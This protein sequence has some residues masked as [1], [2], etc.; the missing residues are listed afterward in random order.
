[1]TTILNRILWIATNEYPELTDRLTQIA[2][3]HTKL[4]LELL[5]HRIKMD[6]VSKRLLEQ[7]IEN[8]IYERESILSYL[9]YLYDDN[10]YSSGWFTSQNS[11]TSE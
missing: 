7:R 9:T 4:N 10:D 3:E 2:W 6:K 8:L 5:K 11:S 1:M